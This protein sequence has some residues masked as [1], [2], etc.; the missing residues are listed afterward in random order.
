MSPNATLECRGVRR[1]QSFS[2]RPK[3]RF[4]NGP[5]RVNPLSFISSP[6]ACFCPQSI[7]SLL[8]GVG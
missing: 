8:D 7:G 5:Y 4:C 2:R 6:E 3:V 1:L